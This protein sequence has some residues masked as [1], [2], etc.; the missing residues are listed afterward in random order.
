MRSV[1]KVSI[2]PIR[3]FLSA[4]VFICHQ[5]RVCD[6]RQGMLQQVVALAQLVDRIVDEICGDIVEGVSQ[7]VELL[8]VMAVVVALFIMYSA[9]GLVKDTLASLLGKPPEKE[10]V[11]KAL[12]R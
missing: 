3:T 5:L 10:Q 9:L 1:S 6:E 2:S 8:G 4:A 11:E 12:C 7:I